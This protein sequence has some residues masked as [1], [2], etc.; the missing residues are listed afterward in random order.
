M[1]FWGKFHDEL[2]NWTLY[3]YFITTNRMKKLIL[4]L[5]LMILGY[6]NAQVTF[7]I[8]SLPA[9]TPPGDYIYIAGNFNSWN[10]GDTNYRLAKNDEQKW[11]ITLGAAAEGAIIQFKFTRGSWATVEKGA[12]GEELNNRLFTYGNG[13]TVGC[14]IYNWA[15]GGEQGSTAAENVEIM[16]ENFE[17]P[18][19]GRTRRIWLYLPPDYATSGMNYPVLYMH[20]GQNLFDDSTSFAGEWH[21][22]ETL[23]A[24]FEQ[25]NKVPIVV[26]IDN[27]GIYR[28]DEYTPWSNPVNGGGQGELYMEFIVQILKPYIDQ[29]YR[30]L[31]GRDFTGIM[32]SSLGGLISHYGALQYQDVFSKAGIFSPSY[33]FS[34]SVWSF[35]R[36]AGVQDAMRIYL[37]CGGA[38]G[39]GTIN[40]MTDMQD[41][42]LAVGFHEDEISMT[43]IPGGQHNETLWSQD[44]GNAYKWLFASYTNDI[45]EHA[46]P[47][48][49]RLFPNPASNIL[50]L[51]A[52]FPDH[53]DSLEVIDMMGKTV[54]KSAPF[55]GREI[56]ISGLV[57]GLYLVSLNLNGKY[58]QGKVVVK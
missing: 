45:P 25:G 11:S 18:Q 39:L 24:F 19:F 55:I 33:W 48:I 54:L 10:P 3:D 51:P 41:T 2:D 1:S 21:V 50:T 30:T 42:L 37:M 35:T 43:V 53:C 22:D 9:Y 6:A 47:N 40:D 5:P 38:E 56:N 17:M 58:F 23:N 15:Q 12:Q 20:D 52:D 49:I 14:I 7:V 29:H 27:G 44:F 26:G 31:P 28:I 57:P 32:G 8:D 13:D 36:L 4:F 16:N 34:D 46:K